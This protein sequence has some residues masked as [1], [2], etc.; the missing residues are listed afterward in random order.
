MTG[1]EGE[2]GLNLWT[3]QKRGIAEV[4]AAIE[5]GERRLCL[6]APTGGGKTAMMFALARH[7]ITADQGVVLYTNR[8]LL[9]EQI[10]KNLTAAGLG[11]G[12]RAADW[13][14]DASHRLQLSSIQTEASRV[15]RGCKSLHSAKLVL[16]D[17]AHAQRGNTARQ[18]IERHLAEGAVLVGVTATPI[19]LGDMYTHLITAGNTSEL[20]SCGALVPATH[21]GPDEPDL[22]RIGRV[23]LG[24]E[25]PEKQ[26][27]AAMMT[28]TIF[29]RVIASWRELNPAQRPTLLFAPGV[30]E[31]KWFAEQFYANGIPAAHIDGEIV[32]VNGKTANTSAAARADVLAAFKACEIRVICNR[33]V[34]REGI[35]VPEV[36]HMILATVIGSLQTYLQIG[37][38]VLRASLSTGKTKAVVQD[39]GGNWWRH[40][41]LNADRSWEL[42]MTSGSVAGI[43]QE[44]LRLKKCVRCREPL[45]TDRAV[46]ACGQLNVVEPRRCPECTMIVIGPKCP[47]GFQFTRW[48]K[49][50]PVVQLDGTLREHSGDIFAPRV[51]REMS[52]TQKLWERSYYAAK[53][54][55]KTFTQAIGWFVQKHGY[56]PPDDLPLMP[57]EVADKWRRVADVPFKDLYPPVRSSDRPRSRRSAAQQTIWP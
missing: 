44:R 56:W 22:K 23:T 3:H 30:G 41:S 26:N 35:D 8:N 34:L 54:S 37:G 48:R 27:R 6:T 55:G 29:S 43:R 14:P 11:H 42:S 24:S 18:I 45:S 10:S 47:C 17:E 28:P 31:S 7:F 49:S 9:L 51:V 38:R 53:R 1:H 5:K 36:E 46:C 25:L 52:D 21:F 39:H 4:L 57:R 33:F 20:R 19:D 32:W 13:K 2:G 50:R 15:I 16:M 12:V 40:G